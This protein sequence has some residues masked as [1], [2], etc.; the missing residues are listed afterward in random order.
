[1]G[2]AVRVVGRHFCMELKGSG[3]GARLVTEAHRG[4][5]LPG[6]AGRRGR[7]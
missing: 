5:P 6:H 1:M 4:A 7:S 2:L 3:P